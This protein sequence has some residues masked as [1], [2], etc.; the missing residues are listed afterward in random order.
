MLA[1]TGRCGVML[2]GV[3]CVERA[4]RDVCVVWAHVS[5]SGADDDAA[6]DRRAVLLER[7]L[8]EWLG[9]HVG[10]VVARLDVN[11]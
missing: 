6:H 9:Q 10:R 5:C 4:V 8:V 2:A 11:K 7:L 3:E 1:T